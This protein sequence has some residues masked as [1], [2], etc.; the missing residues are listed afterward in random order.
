M[1]MDEKDPM[2]ERG[3]WAFLFGVPTF[4]GDSTAQDR[5]GD[6]RQLQG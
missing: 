5:M 3:A 1:S 4:G 6:V 2:D